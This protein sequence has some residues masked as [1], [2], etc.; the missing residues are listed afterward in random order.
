MIRWRVGARWYAAA[1]LTAPVVFTAVHL[2][3]SLASPVFRPSISTM[4]GTAALLLSSI[5]G[6]LAVGFFEELGWTGFAVPALRPRYSAVA[7]A[8]LIGV[9]WG[10][11]HLL[12]N[13]IWI[14]RTYSGDRENSCSRHLKLAMG[15]SQDV[16]LP[17]RGGSTAQ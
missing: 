14:A 12:T 6:A 7:T 5:A 11:W 8:L 13:D 4:S 9:P 3:L 16:T 17:C 2:A 10:A 15:V 1:L